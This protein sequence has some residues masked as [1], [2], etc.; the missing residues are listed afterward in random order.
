MDGFMLHLR[1]EATFLFRRRRLLILIAQL[2]F[3][4]DKNIKGKHKKKFSISGQLDDIY[5]CLGP[6]FERSIFFSYLNL[7]QNM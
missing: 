6:N 5:S 1:L 2:Q 3:K 7:W 4:I